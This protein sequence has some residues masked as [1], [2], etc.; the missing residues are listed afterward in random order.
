MPYGIDFI[1]RENHG[2]GCASHPLVFFIRKIWEEYWKRFLVQWGPSVEA[3]NLPHN[4]THLYM[5][6]TRVRSGKRGCPAGLSGLASAS[7]VA[8]AKVTRANGWE[9]FRN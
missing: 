4:E 3:Y 6:C 5:I 2:P 7:D 9:L 8:A 1:K